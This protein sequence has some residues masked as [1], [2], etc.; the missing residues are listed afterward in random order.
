MSSIRLSSASSRAEHDSRSDILTFSDPSNDAVGDVAEIVEAVVAALI[1]G[2]FVSE[3]DDSDG[4]NK[5]SIA[6]FY[7]FELDNERTILP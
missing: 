5:R 6:M 4:R 7:G 1:I 3:D 2:S